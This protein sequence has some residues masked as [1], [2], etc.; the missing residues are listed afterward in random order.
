VIE[1][2]S[3]GSVWVGDQNNNRIQQ[4]NLNGEYV[5][6]FGTAGSGQGQFNFGWPMGIASD[7]NGNLWIADTGNHRVQRWR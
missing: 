2:D 4:F 5:A 3:K 1:V 6:Q 7:G